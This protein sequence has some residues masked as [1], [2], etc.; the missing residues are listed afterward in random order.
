MDRPLVIQGRRLRP[1]DVA[2]I[3]DW[4]EA[5]PDSN[6]TR[7]S[8]ELCVAWNW[9]NG[10]GRLK[11]MAARSLLLKLE[12]RGHI[13]L[14]PCRTASVNGLRNRQ[15]PPMDHDQ[16]AVDGPLKSLQ[17]VGLEPVA[18]GGSE[19]LF[20]KFLLQRYHYLGHRNCVGQNMKYLARDRDGRPLACLLFG[21][22]AWKSAARDRWIGW[23]DRQRSDHL[24]LV[25]NNARFLILPWVRVP[26]LAS[27][28]LG[29][30]A[31]RL[32][33]DWRR[34]Y[35][36]PVWLVESFVEQPRFAGAC[37]RAA[38]WVAAGRTTGRTRNDDGR[39]PQAPIK[40]VYLKA[41]Q[42]DAQRRLSA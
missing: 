39:G 33:A 23:N 16:R 21:S 35:G 1:E 31:A 38:G 7:L 36:H 30:A 13:R 27:H 20:F 17:P 32:S 26:R 37:Y 25:T 15:A 28:L 19:A 41:L 34:K 24:A 6:R 2:G 14:P 12:A 22:A 9:R 29:R 8:R 40:T 4:L 10:A 42:A 3:R 5:N 11:D 18:E